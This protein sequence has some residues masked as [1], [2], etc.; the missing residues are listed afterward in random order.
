ILMAMMIFEDEHKHLPPAAICDKEGKPLL[1]WRVAILPYVGEDALYKSFHLDEPWDSPHN[2]PL[3]Q[4]MPKIYADPDPTIQAMS[5]SGKTSYQVP[6]GK[7]TIF[8]NNEGATLR[9]ISDGTANTIELVQLD[10][11]H[12]VE[13]SKP[14]DWNVDLKHPSEALGTLTH[15]I[16]GYA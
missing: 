6:V 5:G 12:A 13:W 14:S 4:H 7:E 1:S 16:A 15:L 8:F 2:L 11:Q 3:V 10:S 9:E